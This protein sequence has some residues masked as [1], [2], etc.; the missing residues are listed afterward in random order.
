MPVA[1][2]ILQGRESLANAPVSSR[3]IFFANILPLS[4]MTKVNIISISE[5]IENI[6]KFS[7]I[8][9][10]IFRQHAIFIVNKG[11]G[12]DWRQIPFTGIN[13]P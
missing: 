1:F 2:F 9:V 7:Q 8:A 10:D 4:L 5:L 3:F 6:P 13:H 12:R 11:G